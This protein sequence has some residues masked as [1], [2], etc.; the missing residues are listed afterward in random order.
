MDYEL[1]MYPSEAK[2]RYARKHRELWTMIVAE[3]VE[4]AGYSELREKSG[5]S[6]TETAERIRRRQ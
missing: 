3:A 5:L 1:D 6:R 4:R 2:V